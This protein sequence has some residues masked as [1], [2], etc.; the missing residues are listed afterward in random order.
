MMSFSLR[1]IKNIS[2]EFL[3]ILF[4]LEYE[5]VFNYDQKTQKRYTLANKLNPYKS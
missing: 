4:A 2:I 1:T 3:E 5:E